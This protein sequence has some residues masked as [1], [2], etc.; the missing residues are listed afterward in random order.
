ML[1]KIK[2]TRSE[3]FAERLL[4]DRIMAR[5]KAVI[6]GD[7]EVELAGSIAKQTNLKGDR[8]FDVFILFPKTYSRKQLETLGLRWAKAAIAPHPWTIGYA[9]HPYL[10]ASF[11]ACDADIVPS[12]KIE[13]I[14]EKA[15]SV[16]RSQLHTKWV[17]ARLTEKQRDDV[18]LLK[19]FLKGIDAYGAE[20][21]V[22]GFSGYLC[23]LLVAHYGSF[24]NVIAA[25][26]RWRRPVIDV[27]KH[28]DE[29]ALGQ[30][31][32]T[33][34]IAVDPV[35]RERNVAAVVSE[36][37]LATFVCAARKFL[38]KPSER[39]FFPAK[40]EISAARLRKALAERK[41]V[42]VL[43]FRAPG[44]VPDV[45]WP[46]LKKAAHAVS[47]HLEAA[48]FRL[49][50]SGWWSD[51]KK[52][53]VLLF[54]L[55]VAELSPARKVRGPDVWHAQDLDAFVAAHGRALGGPFIEGTRAV[56]IERRRHT[57]AAS[58]L[59]EIVARPLKYALPSHIAASLRRGFRVLE[60]AQALKNEACT[61]ALREYFGKRMP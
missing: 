22:E 14:S 51:E 53:C 30:K 28:Y 56:A 40:K 13:E 4:A 2:P 44:V 36:A 59:K 27:E 43:L 7:V 55:E 31:F 47:K 58:L 45:L 60:G 17:K 37:S 10:H 11:E 50:G 49:I 15:T 12:Y 5:L 33:P 21:K 25:V 32:P 24:A 18:R 38:K 35:D 39:F 20:L 6:P 52:S 41:N 42:L 23:E 9:E 57:T 26:E 61:L 8:D 19:A 54:E 16:D 34:M 29:R 46:Q 3:E 1:R 48:G